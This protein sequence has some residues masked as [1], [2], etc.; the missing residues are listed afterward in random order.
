MPQ[1]TYEGQCLREAA[2]VLQQHVKDPLRLRS[3]LRHKQCVLRVAGAAQ[4][5]ECGLGVKAE[6]R[7]CGK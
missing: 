6:L 2:H 3:L 4:H 1:P 5:L 7:A